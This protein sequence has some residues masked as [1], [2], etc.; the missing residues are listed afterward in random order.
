MG[1]VF[2]RIM[3]SFIIFVR[4]FVARV[5]LST[6]F[7]V[8]DRM[9]FTNGILRE[10]IFFGKTR[11]V[12]TRSKGC[13]LTIVL[14]FPINNGKRRIIPTRVR[15]ERGRILC[16][17]ARPALNVLMCNDINVPAVEKVS[18][19]IIVFSCEEKACF[20]PEFSD[21]SD[22]VRRTSTVNCVVSSPFIF[23]LFLPMFTVD[24]LIIRLTHIFQVT[25]MIRV[26]AIRVMIANGFFASKNRVGDNAKLSKVRVP[27]IIITCA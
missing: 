24:N 12:G 19:R 9:R 3:G 27:A 16:A 13:F 22:L 6:R 23:V 18:I 14:F 11:G 1:L 2:R 5:N 21:L 17:F 10:P 4:M 7:R 15:R 8:P 25:S 26:C 20:G